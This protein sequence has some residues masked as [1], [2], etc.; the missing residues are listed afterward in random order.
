MRTEDFGARDWE[1]D[2]FC[3]AKVAACDL[4]V[5]IVGHG[6]GGHPEHS[7]QSYTEREFEAAVAANKPRLLF[8]APDDFPLPASLIEADDVRARQRRFRERVNKERF[9]DT[10]TTPYDLAGRAVPAIHNWEKERGLSPAS[11]AE[12]ERSPDYARVKS[13]VQAMGYRIRAE[14][15]LTARR[16]VWMC[17]GKFG[18]ERRCDLIVFLPG[19]AATYDVEW[20]RQSLVAN[21]ALSRGVMMVRRSP[22]PNVTR[23]ARD[24]GRIN[25]FTLQE[26]EPRLVDVDEYARRLE[27][28]VRSE[29]HA[30]L[31]RGSALPA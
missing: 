8:I 30:A 21:E 22:A 19:E 25:L 17:Q 11:R 23:A 1:A 20:L 27:G 12:A 5:G 14:R 15:E 6:Y 28:R 9:R 26:N 16:A 3:R 24:S 13:I 31:L 18:A 10:F 7:E 4:F 2:D 29:R